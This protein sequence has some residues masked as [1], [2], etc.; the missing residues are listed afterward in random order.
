LDFSHDTNGVVATYEL[1]GTSV[2]LL[3]VEY[4]TTEQAT[5]GAQ[6]LQNDPADN[7]LTVQAQDNILV[8]VFGAGDKARAAILTAKVLDKVDNH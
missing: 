3:I 8:A 1:N 4:P 7:L 5:A 2:Y 6:A